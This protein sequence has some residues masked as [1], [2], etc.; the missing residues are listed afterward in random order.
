MHLPPNVSTT[1]RPD[2]VMCLSLERE[3]SGT[4]G[5]S[6]LVNDDPLREDGVAGSRQTD[7][8]TR[9]AGQR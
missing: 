4:H 1:A 9:T 5:A 8:Q 7:R 6:Y 2:D 3:V